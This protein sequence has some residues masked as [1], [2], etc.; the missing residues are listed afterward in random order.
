MDTLTPVE[1]H[2]LQYPKILPSFFKFRLL[3]F[4]L[5]LFWFRIILHIRNTFI[6]LAAFHDR[7]LLAKSVGWKFVIM[8]LNSGKVRHR[9]NKINH[10]AHSLL[11][12]V[13]EWYHSLLP[14]FRFLNLSDVHLRLYFLDNLGLFRAVMPLWGQSQ[15]HRI[16]VHRLIILIF[17]FISF[18]FIEVLELIK[19]FINLLELWNLCFDLSFYVLF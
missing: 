10:S 18:N 7:I 17:I 5:L 12:F 11:F 2:R 4:F 9:H 1:P 3:L 13:I 15:T 19:K 16:V 6:R 8:P 14:T